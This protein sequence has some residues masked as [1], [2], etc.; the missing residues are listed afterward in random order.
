MGKHS[1]PKTA[2][3]A[4]FSTCDHRRYHTTKV[5][6][7]RN[8]ASTA[9]LA[10]SSPPP[11]I[12]WER[13]WKRDKIFRRFTPVA[14]N[15]RQS[16]RTH[17]GIFPDDFPEIYPRCRE[18]FRRP[19]FFQTNGHVGPLQT[20]AIAFLND[21]DNARALSVTRCRVGDTIIWKIMV[22]SQIC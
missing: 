4:R 9:S 16:P 6:G 19:D 17:P 15:A 20:L 3:Q 12:I 1:F 14:K 8:L 21:L 2:R 22:F 13:I 11:G 10:T 7:L 5:I 18:S